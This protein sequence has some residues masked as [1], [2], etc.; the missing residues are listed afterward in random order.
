MYDGRTLFT[1]GCSNLALTSAATAGPRRWLLGSVSDDPYDIRTS[2]LVE[3]TPGKLK[4]VATELSSVSRTGMTERGYV[5]AEGERGRGVNESGFGLNWS[6]VQQE[7]YAPVPGG[8]TSGQFSRLLLSTCSSVE[9]ALAILDTEPRDF[10]GVYFF[11]D[12]GGAM[13]QVEIGRGIYEV[14]QRHSTPDGGSGFNVNCY[15]VLKDKQ[16]PNGSMDVMAAPNYLRHKA[17]TARLA[18]IGGQGD[19]QDVARILADHQYLELPSA[20]ESWIW[21]GHGFSVCNHGT[22]FGTVSAEIIDPSTRTLWYCFGWACGQPPTFEGQV[23]QDRSWGKFLAFNVDA[24][25]PGY[26]TT[27]TGELTSLG[28]KHLNFEN[29]IESAVADA[30]PA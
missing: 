23:Y 27:P 25:P 8:L 10:S 1:G 18:E 9:Q 24:L 17:G 28:V 29:V 5:V 13:A 6:F 3:H 19:L 20:E 16:Y 30:R 21:P 22:L 4:H 14:T 12:A 26:Y 11:A 7:G 15:Q 2:V